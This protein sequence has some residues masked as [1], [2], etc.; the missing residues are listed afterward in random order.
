[1][2]IWNMDMRPSG[3]SLSL[4][5]KGGA[6]L[7][8]CHL[9]S[10]A[11]T[12]DLPLKRPFQNSKPISGFLLLDGESGLLALQIWASSHRITGEL[13]VEETFRGYLVRT[14]AQ[15]RASFKVGSGCSGVLPSQ[16][17]SNSMNVHYTIPLCPCSSLAT[18]AAPVFFTS[19]WNFLCCNL[20]LR[21]L[22]TAI[23]SPPA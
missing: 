10:R 21:Q 4:L 16:V 9:I 3:E 20:C 13:R 11:S 5:E 18:L 2:N 8:I 12:L 23:R 14:T 19:N 7:P 6:E 22:K 15:S 17:L 1:M